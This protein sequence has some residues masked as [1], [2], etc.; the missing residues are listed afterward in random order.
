MGKLL[1]ANIV[2]NKDFE[3]ALLAVLSG[4][5]L[6][7]SQELLLANF[8]PNVELLDDSDNEEA[9]FAQKN[10]KKRNKTSEISCKWIPPTS[11][12]CER[13]FSVAKQIRSPQRSRLFPVHLEGIMFLK[14][15][16]QYW[17][18][19]VVSALKI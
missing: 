5:K 16:P 7:S 13:S 17:D 15:N 19:K 10:L 12:I 6:N 14:L 2:Y 3:N 1:D 9:S 11:N 18:V 4:E 8:G